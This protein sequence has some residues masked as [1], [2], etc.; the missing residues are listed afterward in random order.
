MSHTRG[1]GCPRELVVRFDVRNRRW[2]QR[3]SVRNALYG[4]INER[5]SSS[6]GVQIDDVYSIALSGMRIQ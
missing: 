4:S 1:L 5:G 3:T 6:I 2:V